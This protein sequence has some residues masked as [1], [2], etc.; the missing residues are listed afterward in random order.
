[1]HVIPSTPTRGSGAGG[2][3]CFFVT[4]GIVATLVLAGVAM[5]GGWLLS[6][7]V[8]YAGAPC[9]VPLALWARIYGGLIIGGVALV[10]IMA[11]AGLSDACLTA[12]AKV[13]DY[14]IVP[15]HA[16]LQQT[17]NIGLAGVG[18]WGLVLAFGDNLWPAQQAAARDGTT[19]RCDAALYQPI[20][21]FLIVTWSIAAVALVAACL[22]ACVVLCCSCTC[23]CCRRASDSDAKEDDGDGTFADYARMIYP[24]L[25]DNEAGLHN[26]GGG[27]S[28]TIAGTGTGIGT[29]IGAHL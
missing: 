9:S 8:Q 15:L 23:R 12:Y 26:R 16:M 28:R 18:I 11:V 25:R 29:G 5:M 1:M 17:L 27:A 7:G 4:L 21:L 14:T 13:T 10:L 22:T 19:P 3:T 24:S 2:A 20:A 6:L